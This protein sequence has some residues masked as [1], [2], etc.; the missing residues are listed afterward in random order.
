M[1]SMEV[2]SEGVEAKLGARLGAMLEARMF[3]G[4]WEN[5]ETGGWLGEGLAACEGL[6][7]GCWLLT[8]WGLVT[9]GWETLGGWE[10]DGLGWEREEMEKSRAWE[11]AGLPRALVKLTGG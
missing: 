2:T 5:I 9:R 1:P 11:V 4:S 8:V 7:L 3:R 6:G 10:G